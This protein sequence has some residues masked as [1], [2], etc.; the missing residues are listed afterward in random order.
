MFEPLLIDEV[1]ASDVLSVRPAQLRRM[2]ARGQV[3]CK[4]LPSG[5]K[6]FDP[7]ELREWVSRLQHASAVPA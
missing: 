4:L 3:P 7:S 2:V 6:R 5:E 1:L